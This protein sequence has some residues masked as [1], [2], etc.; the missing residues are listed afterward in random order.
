MA[1]FYFGAAVKTSPYNGN[2]QDLT[3]WYSDPGIPDNYSPTN[4]VPATTFPTSSDTVYFY[5]N[6]TGNVATY[7]GT[8]PSGSWSTDNTFSGD[9]INLHTVGVGIWSGRLKGG[10]FGTGTPWGELNIVGN[11]SNTL[12]II[13]GTF[14]VVSPGSYF[15]VRFLGGVLSSNLTN[16]ANDS[17][18]FY[19]GVVKST[20]DT[21]IGVYIDG[22]TTFY[23][24]IKGKY[25]SIASTCT[26]NIANGI[27][28]CSGTFYQYS[29]NVSI[30]S[31]I[32]TANMGCTNYQIFAGTFS[33]TNPWIFGNTSTGATVTINYQNLKTPY[34]INKNITIYPAG[35]TTLG[36]ANMVFTGLINIVPPPGQNY[37]KVSSNL[38]CNGGTYSPPGIFYIN[39]TP[40][41]SN[42]LISGN[43][44]VQDYG[45]IRNG[46]FIAN[47]VLLNIP[48]T[49]ILTT[50]LL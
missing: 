34:T 14:G 32:S 12:P 10:Y 38:V 26:S 45:F 31:D 49:D 5:Q 25:I 28:Y 27:Q 40:N 35:T 24:P 23:N 19:N 48:A 8:Y 41:G 44:F 33:N 6:V 43:N 15:N 3:Q 17:C 37:L 11:S 16:S 18:F 47:T 7:S 39:T 21:P 1:N 13:N 2:W 30:S 29:S 22:N 9:T 50:Q 4:G 36:A 20:F 42:I 46:I